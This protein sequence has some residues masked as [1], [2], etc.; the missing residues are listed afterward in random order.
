MA[1]IE[2]FEEIK[3]WKKA[4]TLTKQIYQVT[5][6]GSFGRD[7]GLKDQIRRASVSILSNIAEGFEREE[8][9]R[10]FFSF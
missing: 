8:V 5:S 2:K 9:T 3:S 7:F 4:R 6:I 10:N 1:K